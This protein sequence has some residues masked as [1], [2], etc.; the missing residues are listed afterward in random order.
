M[1]KSWKT[2]LLG[3]GLGALNLFANGA[4]PKQVGLSLGLLA[5]G[6][7]AKDHNVSGQ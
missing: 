1:F 2:T 5:L 4:S 7:V 3:L 6:A